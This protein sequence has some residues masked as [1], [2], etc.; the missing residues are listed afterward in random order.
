MGIKSFKKKGNPPVR[1][2]RCILH[3]LCLDNNVLPDEKRGSYMSKCQLI[4]W[5]FPFCL[6]ICDYI[7]RSC[8]SKTQ[9]GLPLHDW[10]SPSMNESESRSVVSDSLRPHDLY[11]PWNSPGHNIG[12]GSHSFLLQ[13]IFPTQGS[14]PGLPHCRQIPSQ[15][16]CQSAFWLGCTIRK[17]YHL[18]QS[19]Q[20]GLTMML[21]VLRL[22]L[23]LVVQCL[24]HV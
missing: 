18:I 7:N 9:M 6:N 10:T 21:S 22:A 13:G 1:H 23:L 3:Q 4:C 5:V 17:Q 8:I 2:L 19:S 15:L 16:S 24:F 14:N 20:E 11:S 12:V